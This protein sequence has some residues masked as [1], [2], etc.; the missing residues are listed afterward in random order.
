MS[1]DP[2]N[3]ISDNDSWE[4]ISDKSYISISTNSS[5]E[6]MADDPIETLAQ[7]ITTGLQAANK[8]NFSKLVNVPF[9]CGGP[10]TFNDKPD[11]KCEA[12]VVNWLKEIQA[13][14]PDISWDE[15]GR[16]E[17]AVQYSLGPAHTIALTIKE[18][19]PSTSGSKWK[20]F[21][22]EFI[23]YFPSD[24][25]VDK[26]MAEMTKISKISSE[27]YLMFYSKLTK[28]AAELTKLGLPEP[29][30]TPLVVAR[31]LESAPVSFTM[32]IKESDRT[33]TQKLWSKF[34]IYIQRH[35]ELEQAEKE[36]TGIKRQ[37]N[38]IKPKETANRQ[39][40]QP[41]RNVS[42]NTGPTARFGG[43]GRNGER[44]C[45]RCGILGHVSTYCRMPVNRI[46]NFSRGP[47]MP[48]MQCHR[49]HGYSH[50]ARFCTT[51]WENIVAT[52]YGAQGYH[53]NYQGY[54]DQ[55][56]KN[57]D[58]SLH[59]EVEIKGH[60]L[61]V[62]GSNSI[63]PLIALNLNLEDHE[64][65]ALLDTGAVASLIT[66]EK[67]AEISNTVEVPELTPA[68]SLF[69]VNGK[70]L[71]TL[72]K[73]SLSF[74]LGNRNIAHEFTVVDQI[75]LPTPVLLGNDFMISHKIVLQT[76]PLQLTINHVKVNLVPLTGNSV[77][78]VKNS[79]VT[80]RVN[81]VKV[82]IQEEFVCSPWSH[83]FVK[84]FA[85]SPESL[86][87]ILKSREGGCVDS[88][89]QTRQSPPQ[90]VNS[91]GR[92]HIPFSNPCVNNNKNIEVI[93]LFSAKEG[94]VLANNLF[95]GLVNP[96]LENEKIL[97]FIQYVNLSPDEV[98]LPAQA[99]VGKLEFCELSRVNAEESSDHKSD[100]IGVISNEDKS[101]CIKEYVRNNFQHLPEIQ[102]NVLLATL[103]EFNDV[104]A[105]NDEELT[106]SPYFVHTIETVSE[107]PVYKR[108]YP[109]PNKYIEEVKQQ[110]K[111]MVE[112]GII[113]PSRS[114]YNSPLVPVLKKD[115]KLRLCLDFRHLNT[116]I[117]NDRYPLPNIERIL[118]QLGQ[119]QFFSCLDL[120]QGYH[121]IALDEKSKQKTAFSTSFGQYE[122]AVLPFGLKDAPTSFQ[123]I[124]NQ[125]LA[126]QIGIKAH[127][128]LDDIIVVG[129]TFEEH[130]NNLRA[131][132][133]RL[134]ENVLRLKL[135][136]CHF[137]KTEVDYLG[138]VVNEQ[139]IKP[140]SAKVQA[141]KN[142]ALPKNIQEL[143][144]FLGMTN[145]YRK[146]VFNYSEIVTPLTRLTGGRKNKGSDKTPITMN[147]TEK[148]AFSKLK[149]VLSEDLILAYPDFS[150]PFILTT[151]SSSFAIGGVLQQE[152]ANGKLRPLSYFSRRLNKAE[153]KYSTVER[154]ALAIVY[155]LKY[156]RSLILGYPIIIQTDH[157][158]L[159]WLL[160][161]AN[162]SGRV[163][164]WQLLTLEYD[165]KT[166][167]LPGKEN[168][169]ADALSRLR[170]EVDLEETVLTIMGPR[171]RI[172]TNP[173]V[174]NVVCKPHRV[175]A[176]RSDSFETE[177]VVSNIN[178]IEEDRVS[179]EEERVSSNKASLEMN[180]EE[181][182]D[183]S[184]KYDRMMSIEEDR[185]SSEE[186]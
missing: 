58:V 41:A 102:R 132:L 76:D 55:K 85:N 105:L 137:L 108:P 165:I 183:S 65:L 101:E 89:R 54:N 61:K 63:S 84:V 136:K 98:V 16:I 140:Q 169:V 86:N 6:T 148:K 79:F 2:A 33:D 31:F 131:V 168:V 160:T 103:T 42:H 24:R 149:E 150:K 171:N 15:T 93:A 107:T 77:E 114:A 121:Q 23:K 172:D 141:I 66:K 75:Q 100:F 167:Y 12:H 113:R 170:S 117:K 3:N 130:I 97:F 26:V 91:Q 51:P 156:N 29:A 143:Q 106:V 124:I 37:I 162:P 184:N 144:S 46:Y 125:V 139:G 174:C 70:P 133:L 104:F 78:V 39:T 180:F 151:D 40:S 56:K 112:Q 10:I 122:Y 166:L 145:Y 7:T 28:L 20:K 138:H 60:V 48:G 123:R 18:A 182:R 67:F 71:A 72:G 120:K 82:R 19:L 52:F 11:I 186:E 109:I 99:I 43:P 127:V 87:L 178:I 119:S 49:C 115:G 134:R 32:H 129:A 146:F 118:T 110:I 96:R 25:T 173:I 83:G 50:T 74:K 152:D 22:D 158:P 1:H 159:I 38:A 8:N 181:E 47:H 53:K 69:D 157:R 176:V 9:Y 177:R 161:T 92:S 94:E 163:A 57:A 80:K 142:L 116:V 81:P 34:L 90:M 128:Y 88:V 59:S 164:R 111:T 36:G 44:K 27:S 73:V 5:S 14:T 64:I 135:E 126:G 30:V 17:V 13:K 185:V 153:M 62:G 95:S 179:S 35:P 68:Q 4:T 175:C 155:A 147:E 45:N 21:S 154:E